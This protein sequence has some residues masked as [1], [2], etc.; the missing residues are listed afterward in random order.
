MCTTSKCMH[1]KNIGQCFATH[2]KHEHDRRTAA[3]I[4]LVDEYESM[5]IPALKMTFTTVCTRGVVVGGGE[6][7]DA[8]CL[9]TVH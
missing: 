1:M 7:V 2:G 3:F 5:S 6:W 4:L 9:A 8:I